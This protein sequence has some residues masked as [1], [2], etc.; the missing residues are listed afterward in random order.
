MEKWAATERRGG[1]R[2][3]EEGQRKGRGRAEEGQK[4]Q[5]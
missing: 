2:R 1:R 5:H 4:S 3:A